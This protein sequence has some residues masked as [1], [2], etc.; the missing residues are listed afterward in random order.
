MMSS[1][2]TPSLTTPNTDDSILSL[3][4]I[5]AIVAAVVALLAL[6]VSV[7]CCFL[8]KKKPSSL[9]PN[10]S[11][12]NVEMELQSNSTQEFSSA[13]NSH[14]HPAPT[15]SAGT[16]SSGAGEYDSSQRVLND[17]DAAPSQPYG[18]VNPMLQTSNSNDY[19]AAPNQPYGVV[20]SRPNNAYDAAPN[21]SC[22][23]IIV[24]FLLMIITYI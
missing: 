15:E 12:Q 3:D 11:T 24:F 21:H 17:Y 10:V 1:S 7:G 23:E 20:A 16:A 13:R 8:K 9:S 18:L 4:L 2:T 6:I 5:I 19:D 14:Y 22:K